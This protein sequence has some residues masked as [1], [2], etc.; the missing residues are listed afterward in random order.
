M[1]KPSKFLVSDCS[2]ICL[3]QEKYQA[4]RIYKDD[5]FYSLYYLFV[6]SL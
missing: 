4:I 2:Q 6:D 3:D 5:N 1:L